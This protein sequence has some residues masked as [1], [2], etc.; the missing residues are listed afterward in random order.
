MVRDL[1]DQASESHDLGQASARD[2][3]A[4]CN[5]GLGADVAGVE[6]ALSLLGLPEEFD[7][8]VSL[9]LLGRLG[10]PASIRGH[11]RDPVGGDVLFQCASGPVLER[12]LGDEGDFDGLFAQLFAR[13]GG[14][15]VRGGVLDSDPNFFWTL[16]IGSNAVSIGGATG[17][18]MR[19]A[20]RLTRTRLVALD[21]RYCEFDM[22]RQRHLEEARPPAGRASHM[23]HSGSARAPEAVAVFGVE[24]ECGPRQRAL[25]GSSGVFRTLQ[26]T[27][28]QLRPRRRRNVRELA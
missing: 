14:E 9:R 11:I 6:L 23:G 24:Q 26:P 25:A 12:H 10:R 2:A 27:G 8:P 15:V 18:R 13:Y 28:S 17:T 22:A 19:P 7:H 4:T 16:P 20:G 1:G 3:F 21:R 5:L